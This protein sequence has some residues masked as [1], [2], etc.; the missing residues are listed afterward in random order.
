VKIEIDLDA[1]KKDIVQ[2]VIAGLAPLLRPRRQEDKGMGLKEVAE[3]TGQK[4]RWIYDHK[5]EI[6]HTKKDGLLIFK[7]SCIDKWLEPD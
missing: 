2:D 6:P 3:Y 1:L 4:P 5:H 7:K